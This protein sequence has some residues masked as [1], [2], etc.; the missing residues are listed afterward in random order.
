MAGKSEGD[1]CRSQGWTFPEPI[2]SRVLHVRLEV[3]P[4]HPTPF[5]QS[6]FSLALAPAPRPAPRH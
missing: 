2:Y 3:G 1:L 5:L 4:R 6:L